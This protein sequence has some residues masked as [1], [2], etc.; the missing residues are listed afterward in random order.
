MLDGLA[1]AYAEGVFLAAV[2]LARGSWV[3]WH[4]PSNVRPEAR[5][6]RSLGQI[7]RLS[8]EAWARV[9]EG[10]WDDE[11]QNVYGVA[12][13]SESRRLGPETEPIPPGRVPLRHGVHRGRG[14]PRRRRNVVD[15]RA[16]RDVRLLGAHDPR[17]RSE[18]R[19]TTRRPRERC[20]RG[21]RVPALPRLEDRPGAIPRRQG[22]SPRASPLRW[23]GVALRTRAAPAGRGLPAL[24]SGE[25]RPFCPRRRTGLP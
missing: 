25:R 18:E 16:A 17:P 12:L 22:R 5:H 10:D 14:H 21:G 7:A 2:L 8:P 24:R 15:P 19:T 1:E 23:A 20:R 11:A 3:W 13:R 9:A 4:P 6:G